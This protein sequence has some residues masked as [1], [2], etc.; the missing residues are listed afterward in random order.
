MNLPSWT[1]ILSVLICSGG[2]HAYEPDFGQIKE[3]KQMPIGTMAAIASLLGVEIDNRWPWIS[4]IVES[5][6]KD[7]LGT[8]QNQ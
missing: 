1:Y 3:N 7:G 2:S 6:V 4:I 8:F 5:E